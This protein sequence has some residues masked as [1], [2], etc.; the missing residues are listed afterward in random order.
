MNT[1]E[2]LE[3][4]ISKFLRVGVI[5][6]GI[7]MLVGWMATIKFKGDPF[8]NFTTYD[9]IPLKDLIEYHLAYGNYGI[10]IS[11][12][13]LIT[14]ISLPVIRV[15]LTTYLF[16]RQ[17]EF[18]LATIAFVVLTGLLVSMTLGIEL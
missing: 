7:L 12:T 14:L 11:Y 2:E 4:K 5:I 10:L 8:F 9:E 6:A 17:K 13:G 3:L 15:F 18:A 1:M 16:I